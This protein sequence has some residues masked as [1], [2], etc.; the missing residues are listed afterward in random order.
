MYKYNKN[1]HV[2]L[3]G[4]QYVDLF[5]QNAEVHTICAM[6]CVAVLCRQQREALTLMTNNIRE[7]HDLRVMSG[8]QKLNNKN[9]GLL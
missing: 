9:K 7:K 1:V 2:C 3:T 8:S 4:I 6:L 5:K